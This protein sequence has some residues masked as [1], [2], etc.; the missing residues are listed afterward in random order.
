MKASLLSA[1]AFVRDEGL[2][3][4]INPLMFEPTSAS[5]LEASRFFIQLSFVF[6][7]SEVNADDF[8]FFTSVL[9]ELDAP[10]ASVVF[11][12]LLNQLSLMPVHLLPKEDGVM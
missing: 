9:N 1:K 11:A 3:P 12:A 6:R 2:R 8:R 7:K 5:D 10:L 4:P